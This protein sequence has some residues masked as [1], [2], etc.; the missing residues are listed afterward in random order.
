METQHVTLSLPRE[1]LRQ[2]KAVAAARDASISALLTAAL[3]E[4]VRQDDRYR[5]A[6][7]RAVARARQGYDLGSAGRLA[8]GRD[9]LHAR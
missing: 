4:T 9:E 6:M 1:L 3:E 7:R 8:T 5:R 2:V